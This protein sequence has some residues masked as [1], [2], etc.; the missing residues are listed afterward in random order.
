MEHVLNTENRTEKK[1]NMYVQIKNLQV[2]S[3]YPFILRFHLEQ[4]PAKFYNT[5]VNYK[6]NV[7][8]HK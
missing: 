8:A 3:S 2:F 6:I 4:V 1:Y 5:Y 7:F